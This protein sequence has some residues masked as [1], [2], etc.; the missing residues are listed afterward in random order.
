MLKKG[1][2]L[3]ALSC[4]S[5]SS[6]VFLFTSDLSR[7]VSYLYTRPPARSLALHPRWARRRFEEIEGRWERSCFYAWVEWTADRTAEKR[8]KLERAGRTLRNVAAYRSFRSW[9]VRMSRL[10]CRRYSRPSEPGRT[11]LPKPFFTRA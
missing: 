7:V 4:C 10:Y 8:R 3:T 9:Q 1:G 5:S 6:P 2:G 11:G